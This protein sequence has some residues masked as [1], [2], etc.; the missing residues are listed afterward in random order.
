[1]PIT[2]NRTPL[3]SADTTTNWAAFGAV[4]LNS[5][6]DTFIEG[7]ASVSTTSDNTA[8]GE[9]IA[10]D[11]GS[12]RDWTNEV[13]YIWVNIAN[14]GLMETFANGGIRVRAANNAGIGNYVE[15]N[16]AGSDTYSGG[17]KMFVI[18]MDDV[19]A[20]ADATGGTPPVITAA[21]YVGIVCDLITG[22]MPKMQDNLF[23]DA[24][25]RLNKNNPGIIITGTNGGTPWNWQ[26]V[27]DAGDIGDTTKAWGH[28]Q[29]IEGNIVFTAPVRF[30]DST[31][32][33]DN[34]EFEDTTGAIVTFG[35]EVVPDDFYKIDFRNDKA[36]ISPTGLLSVT[37]GSFVG[38]GDDRQGLNGTFFT[39]AGPQ[40]SIDGE[41][42]SADIDAL[43]FYGC[44][45]VNCQQFEIAGNA[46]TIGTSFTGC[47][48]VRPNDSEFLNN[49]IIA[50]RRR[51]LELV[52]A[53]QV[54]QC[55]FI[56]NAE[57][58]P[59][60][61]IGTSAYNEVSA[62]STAGGE[63]LA[64]NYS[65]PS[66]YQNT[67][68]LAIF[69]FEDLGGGNAITDVDYNGVSFTR[70]GRIED[71]TSSQLIAEV[72]ILYDPVE[73]TAQNVVVTSSTNGDSLC[74]R[75]VSLAGVPPIA[76]FV[77][78]TQAVG[79][80]ASAS[81]TFENVSEGDI[82]YSI[83]FNQLNSNG[84]N[85]SPDG[86][87]SEVR[88]AGDG[89]DASHAQGELANTPT[90]HIHDWS[91]SNTSQAVLLALRVPGIAVEHAVHIPDGASGS[92]LEG[93]I[94]LDNLVFFGFDPFGSPS[95]PKYVAEVSQDYI[96]LLTLTA[97][98]DTNATFDDVD[99]T[100]VNSTIEVVNNVQITLTG[101]R[102]NTEVR[103][104]LFGT[105]TEVDGIENATDGT[106]DDR[107][108]A[109]TVSS[110]TAITIR[111]INID[112][113][114][115][116]DNEFDLTPTGDQVIP[117]TQIIDRNYENP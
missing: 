33:T 81:V 55:N 13:V 116:P 54:K 29:K 114:V 56:A 19:F 49:N 18:D 66:G 106:T 117:I 77:V 80:G 36:A 97:V 110:G 113:V 21:R 42:D 9:G 90:D 53:H 22:A 82:T 23:V 47:G 40:Y 24:A 68:I 25:W 5:D 87:Q 63:N 57:T 111:I 1:M 92:P 45:I 83:L 58:T 61:A 34:T 85:H 94:N 103:V 86:N 73:D 79:S 12:D 37:F 102:D 15:R 2:D 44:S 51:G 14:P 75:V 105:T 89:A 20:N 31:G 91:W 74:G 108:F 99:V 38:S 101:M 26:D 84:G 64:T 11:N 28:V 112:Y 95:G 46:I 27:V 72:W 104:Y 115:P 76:D 96:D 35:D 39:T 65:H 4:T 78:S 41:T 70:I 16:L 7:S 67:A 98:G 8:G 62:P 43:N 52:A 71:N 100:G 32:L 107:S 109:F 93:A 60:L 48:E 50:A 59:L 30:G 3:D 88:D 10:F 6:T 17:W 69:G